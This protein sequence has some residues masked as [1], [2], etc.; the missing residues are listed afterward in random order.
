MAN[1]A[2]QPTRARGGSS[3]ISVGVAILAVGLFLGWLATTKPPEVATVAEPGATG[4]E[5]Q[6]GDAVAATSIEP[7][8]LAQDRQLIGEMVE[9]RSVSVSSP[10]GPQLFWIELPGGT[11]YLV[12]LDS[13][14]VA[15]ATQ[16]PA[17]RRVYIVGQ[18]LEKTDAVVDEWME[19]GVLQSEDHR[20]QALF[21]S[22]YIEARTVRPAAS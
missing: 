2:P 10:L 18:V 14:L 22:T 6:E 19:S 5:G 8:A 1:K 9:L 3:W 20:L 12:K 17:G 4:Q 11:P 13:T 21:G 7:D 16:V 15:R